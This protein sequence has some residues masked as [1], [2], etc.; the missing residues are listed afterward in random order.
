MNIQLAVFSDSGFGQ[1][2]IQQR[3]RTSRE[4]QKRKC[5]PRQRGLGHGSHKQKKRLFQTRDKRVS[6]VDY[7]TGAD[8][9]ITD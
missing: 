8:P 4:L 2:P 9:E 3:D 7:L 5:F 1:H 6:Y